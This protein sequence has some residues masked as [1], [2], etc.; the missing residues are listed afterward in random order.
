MVHSRWHDSCIIIT[1]I[2]GR[3]PMG[4]NKRGTVFLVVTVVIMLVLLAFRVRIN[5]TAQ[6]CGGCCDVN[7]HV[8]QSQK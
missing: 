3:F 2:V 8:A 1:R 5:K 6:G 7:A 4:S